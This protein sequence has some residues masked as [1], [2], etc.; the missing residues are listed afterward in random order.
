MAK[1]KAHDVLEMQEELEKRES[2]EQSAKFSVADENLS[3]ENEQSNETIEEID[4]STIIEEVKDSTNLGVSEDYAEEKVKQVLES[5]TPKKKRKSTIISLCLLLVNLIFMIYII[6]GLISNVGD[7]NILDVLKNQG[8]KLWWLAGGLGVYVI[9]ILVQ[10][11]MYYILVR[12][13]AG[14]KRFGLAYDVAIVGKYYDN[15][16]PFAVGGQPMQILRLSK[17]GISAGIS[18][19]IPIIK[20]MFNSAVNMIIA[21]L[22]FIFGVPK[23]PFS[24][25]LNDLLLILLIIVGVIGLIIT[26]IVVVFMFLIASGSLITRSFI[27]N[28]LRIGYKLKLVKNYRQ[29][30]QKMLNQ[31]AEYKVS[32]NFMWKNKKTL[33]KILVL[34]VF[35]CLSYAIMPYVIV[36]AF[37]T[38]ITM[39]AGLF[40]VVCISQYYICFMASTVIPLPGG[41]GIMEIAFIFLFG[42]VV[43]DN[44]VW[45]LL[46]WRILSYYMIIVHGFINELV[47]I[48][49]N[50]SKN[51][52]KRVLK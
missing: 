18:T 24:S 23:I 22:F 26:I 8:S 11:L 21:L 20:M 14:K 16:T 49:I 34:C 4:T 50:F 47:H 38:N 29:S 33:L 30:F 27:S 41:T 31:V 44:I 19:S 17:S 2:A 48:G 37:A 15:V 28:I 43:G 10:V 51:R 36:Q 12:D 32:F 25:P 46:A 39:S 1:E 45:A 42:I 40:L 52:K 3:K 13:I 7:N 35:E 9:Y 5:Q 6:K